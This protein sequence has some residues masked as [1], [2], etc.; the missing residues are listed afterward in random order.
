MCHGF[1]HSAQEAAQKRVALLYSAGVRSDPD[2][3]E[4]SSIDATAS[5]HE[6]LD[7]GL[8]ATAKLKSLLEK[9]KLVFEPIKGLPPD[10]GVGHT[11]PLHANQKPPFRSP[12][13]LSPLENK[14]V[15]QQVR[16]V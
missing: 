12:Y 6:S 15:E 16:E 10:R 9:H 11:I 14:E 4:Q 13:R 8:M 5:Q 1:G 7:D 3:S 2:A